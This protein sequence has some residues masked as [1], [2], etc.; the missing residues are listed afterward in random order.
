MK[1][2]KLKRKINIFFYKNKMASLRMVLP[3]PPQQRRQASKQ[4]ANKTGRCIY[5]NVYIVM[6][7]T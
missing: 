6:M 2:K 7:Y 5:I 3:S 1:E 4:G